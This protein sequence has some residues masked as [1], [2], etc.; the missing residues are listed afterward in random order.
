MFVTGEFDFLCANANLRI[1]LRPRP[2]LI[3]HGNLEREDDVEIEED[4][5]EVRNT[6]GSWS[7]NG[8][9]IYRHHDELPLKFYDIGNANSRSYRN[10]ST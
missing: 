4:D 10:T 1:P 7:K 8:K 2:L 5:N 6:E 9:W 3:A